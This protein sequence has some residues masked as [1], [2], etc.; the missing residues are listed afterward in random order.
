MAVREPPAVV[1]VAVYV[2][3]VLLAS[4]DGDV[5]T[6]FASVVSVACAAPP[7]KVAPAP[8]ADG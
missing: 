5:A 3:A 1:A 8:A 6:P 7:T 4:S 2:P